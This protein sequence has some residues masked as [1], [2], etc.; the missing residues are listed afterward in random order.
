MYDN[1]VHQTHLYNRSTLSCYLCITVLTTVTIKVKTYA[2]IVYFYLVGFYN[3][4]Q[5]EGYTYYINTDC[6]CHINL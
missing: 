2:E 4:F 5:F 1:H 6:N 3:E